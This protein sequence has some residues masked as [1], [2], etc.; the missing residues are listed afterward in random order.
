[1]VISRLRSFIDIQASKKSRSRH[2][3]NLEMTT[4]PSRKST[5]LSHARKFRATFFLETSRGML[6]P[7]RA[8]DVLLFESRVVL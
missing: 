6:F 3:R 4:L 5:N 8:F 7:P 1:M 2:E